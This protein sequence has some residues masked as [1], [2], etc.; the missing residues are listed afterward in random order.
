M[1]FT[2]IRVILR[3]RYTQGWIQIFQFK[4]LR[5]LHHSMQIKLYYRVFL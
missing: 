2:E 4:V 1:K 3:D 5:F